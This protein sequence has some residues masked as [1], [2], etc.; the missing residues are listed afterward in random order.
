MMEEKSSRLGKLGAGL[1][2]VALWLGTAALG[3]WEIVIIRDM[4]VRIFAR[5]FSD[6]KAYGQDYWG[7]VALGNWLVLILAIV[8]IAMVMGLGEYHFKH[9]G[10]PKSWKWFGRVIAVQLAILVLAFFI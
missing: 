5:L 8:W 7:G 6:G 4:V 1:L 10:E 9:F 2:A 3:L